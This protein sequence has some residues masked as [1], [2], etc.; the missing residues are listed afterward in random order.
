MLRRLFQRQLSLE[1]GDRK[2]EFPGVQEFEFALASR[3][4]V[5]AAKVAELIQLS[6][7]QLLKEAGKIREAE[8]RFVDLVAK[9]LE[10]PG[11]I[12]YLLKQGEPKQFSQDHEWRDIMTALVGK[13]PRFNEFKQV[14]VVKYV[15][16]LS[17]RQDVLKSLYARQDNLPG[18]AE[19]DL[20]KSAGLDM[21]QTLIFD[22]ADVDPAEPN[23]ASA[24]VRVPRGETV[25]VRLAEAESMDLILS[26]HHFQLSADGGAHLMDDNGRAYPLRGGRNHVGRQPGNDV[27]VEFSFRDVSRRHLVI[28]V[29]Q[30]GQFEITDLSSHGTFIPQSRLESTIRPMIRA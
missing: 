9:S 12:G 2:I 27:V 14:A 8:K 4:E 10:E 6:P 26:R 15:Q 24:F 1:V 5:P 23:S 7:D 11:S 28:E 22:V 30:D 3:T 19:P 17:S 18:P 16:Y 29:G 21:K 25:A 20:N 13:G